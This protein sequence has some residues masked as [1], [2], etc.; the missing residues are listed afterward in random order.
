MGI[1]GTLG[2]TLATW[3]RSSTAIFCGYLL[4]LPSCCPGEAGKGR[5][6]HSPLGLT[7]QR[8][9]SIKIDL[10]PN[11]SNTL[12]AGISPAA[13]RAQEGFITHGANPLIDLTN[14]CRVNQSINCTLAAVGD[15]DWVW[16]LRN[17][18]KLNVSSQVHVPIALLLLE[19]I[20]PA[21]TLW[22]SIKPMSQIEAVTRDVI[23][24]SSRAAAAA[25]ERVATAATTAVTAVTATMR[26]PVLTRSEM[27]LD[28]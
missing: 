27:N 13:C 17:P 26:S 7:F 22:V 2:G 16:G 10:Q 1:G 20:S 24:V 11:Q 14:V 12:A 23:V 4:R 3:F 15:I 6:T 18:P 25:A 19:V 5:M 21:C 8:R 28:K 9:L